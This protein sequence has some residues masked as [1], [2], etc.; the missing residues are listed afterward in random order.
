MFYVNPPPPKKKNSN[1]FC[2]YMCYCPDFH[3]EIM[4]IFMIILLS[5]FFIYARMIYSNTG[6][7]IVLK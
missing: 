6:A 7:W 1:F 5:I 4:S 2:I 3:V